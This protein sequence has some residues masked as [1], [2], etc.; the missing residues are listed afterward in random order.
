M[1]RV[2]N[3]YPQICDRDNLRLAWCKARRGKM[4]RPDVRAFGENLD[5]ELASLEADL[6]ARRW[7][8]GNYR[9]FTIYDPK[10]RLITAA[11]FRERVLHHAVMN[12]CEPYFERWQLDASHACR[13]GRGLD[14]ALAVA[15]KMARRHP[16]HLKLDIRKY[17][18]SIPHAPLMRRL[19]RRF[20]DNDLLAL[21]SAIVGTYSV[22]PAPGE[23][24]RGIPIGN[25]TSQFF[26]NFYLEP[27]DRFV[28]ERLRVAGYVRYMDDF[29]L[30]GEGR[31]EMK[32]L[33]REIRG[34]CAGELLLEVKPAVINRSGAGLPFLGYVLRPGSVKLSL[35]A[36]RRFAAGIARADKTEDAQSALAL[37][38]FARRADSTAWR[39]KVLFGA[40]DEGSNRVN[41]GGSWNNNARNCRS[42]NRNYNTP[43]NRNNN[44][45]FRV[46]LLSAQE[47][48]DAAH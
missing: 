8:V 16:W 15:R 29:V 43:G 3:L 2:G 31:E 19:M 42:A 46:A 35:R 41:R 44:L 24:G 5:A 34:F 23:G 13:K 36:K 22:A 27:L 32:R 14:S 6:R 4:G 33:D 12:V 20:K 37:L 26:A 48:V 40:L 1:R 17:F 38:S 11:P 9:H 47:Q 45:G 10:E 30:W 21:F 18:D 25:L 39:R 28:K 7:D